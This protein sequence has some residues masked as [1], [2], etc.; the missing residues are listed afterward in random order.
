MK[1]LISVSTK[2]LLVVLL[3]ALGLAAFPAAGAAAAGPAEEGNPPRQIDT[4]R[5]EQAYDRLAD[6]YTYQSTWMGNA[7]ANIARIQELINKAGERGY[8]ASAVQAA[9]NAFTAV[10][11]DAMAYN[12]QAGAIL[13]TH[14]GFDENGAVTDPAA[15]LETV[16]SLQAALKSAHDTMNGTGQA[17]KDAIRAFR[18]ANRPPSKP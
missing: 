10:L 2:V 7:D 5:L 11:P 18:D 4:A 14:A 16:R 17:L 9:L 3:A 12:Q 6:W 13:S 1:K 15:A 8:D